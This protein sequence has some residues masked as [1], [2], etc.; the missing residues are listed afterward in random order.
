MLLPI[1]HEVLGPGLHRFL[2]AS[3]TRAGVTHELLLD[4]H[5]QGPGRLS[6]LCEAALH[7]RVCKHKRL[8]IL[9]LELSAEVE[10][11]GYLKHRKGGRPAVSS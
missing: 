8:F 5:E 4:L 6:C 9:G 3:E 1:R 10:E 7:G 2:F 11:N